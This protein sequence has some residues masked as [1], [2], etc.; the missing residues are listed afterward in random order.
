MYARRRVH[1][2]QG[3]WQKPK[4]RYVVRIERGG[5]PVAGI[6]FDRITSVDE[7]MIRWYGAH[8]IHEWFVDNVQDGIDDCKT[9]DVDETIL[10]ELLD[11]CEKVINASKLVEGAV[12]AGTA[13]VQE[14][15]SAERGEPDKVIE[16]P[17]VA[18]ELLP[19]PGAYGRGDKVYNEVY[20]EEVVRTRDWLVKLFAA[21]K[22]GAL[23]YIVYSSSW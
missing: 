14:T 8:H 3:D 20:L 9:Y 13:R 5:Q 23:N 2:E 21:P 18:K 19:I 16:N 11:C 4:D 6:Q 12:A 10:R 7:E 1:V 17:T 15:K 22:V